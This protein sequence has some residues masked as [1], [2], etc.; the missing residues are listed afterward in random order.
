MAGTRVASAAPTFNGVVEALPAPGAV[1]L[2]WDAAT[3]AQGSVTYNVYIG[4]GNNPVDYSRAVASVQSP[5]WVLTGLQAG[6]PVRVAVRAADSRGEERN[7]RTVSVTPTNTFPVEEW[8][9]AWVTRF[10]WASGNRQQ[11]EQ[12]LNTIFSTLAQSGLNAVVFQVRGQGDTLYPSPHEPW[13]PLLSESARSFDPI[14]HAVARARENNVEF[15]A[16][17]NLSTIWQ[18]GQKNPP[19]DRNHPYFRMAD[20][21]SPRT[22]QGL[23]HDTN[24]RPIQWGKDGYVWLTHGNP[25]VNTY[26]RQQIRHFIDTYDVHGLHWD[27]RTGNPNGVSRDPVSV[28][29]FNGMGNPMRMSDFGAWQLDQLTRFLSDVYTMA[30][31]KNPRLLISASPFGIADR[32]RIPGYGRYSDGKQ[33]G[34]EPE[35]W[36]H[37]GVLDVLMPQIYWAMPDPGPHYGTLVR[38]WVRHNRS[39]RPIWPGSNLRRFGSDQPLDPVQVRYVALSRALGLNGNQFYSWSAATPA[40]WRAA[41]PLMYPRPARVPVPEHM[42]PGR[43]GQVMGTVTD[44]AG[45]PVVDCWVRIEGRDYTYLSCFDGF[46]GIPNLAPGNYRV[47]FARSRGNIVTRPVTIVADRTVTLDVSIE[48]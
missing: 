2:R 26:L 7:T 41:G 14:A 35:R 13:S 6:S 44:Q 43:T 32:T 22:S 11:I 20:A 47:Q 23:V 37:L 33:F 16:W 5:D 40:Q 9:A 39:G 1:Y 31:A 3:G 36:L 10:E 30:K 21:S 46:Y 25:R 48:R 24:G 19:G 34:V 4:S 29:R 18:S 15:H 17:M 38:D 8:R 28:S 27:D 42:K 12:R 45:K